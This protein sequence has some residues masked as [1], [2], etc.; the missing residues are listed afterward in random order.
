MSID[1]IQG[2][3]D[4]THHHPAYHAAEKHVGWQPAVVCGIIGRNSKTVH[5]DAAE[6]QLEDYKED[7]KFGF[8]S[9][10]VELDHDI[11]HKIGQ[12]P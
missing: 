5:T 9:P 4:S 3:G 11:V 7:T 8:V 10:L 12:Q 6:D 2:A 1:N